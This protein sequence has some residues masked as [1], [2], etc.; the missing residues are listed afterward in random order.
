MIITQLS[1]SKA[2]CE[3]KRR[4]EVRKR[5]VTTVLCGAVGDMNAW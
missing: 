1:D 2:M 3:E 5:G 4:N